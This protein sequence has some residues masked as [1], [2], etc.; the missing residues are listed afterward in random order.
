M[1]I[2]LSGSSGGGPRVWVSSWWPYASGTLELAFLCSMFQSMSA[3]PSRIAHWRLPLSLF[4]VASLCLVGCGVKQDSW[5]TLVTLDLACLSARPNGWTNDDWFNHLVCPATNGL[6][7]HEDR[8]T[9]Q[10]RRLHTNPGWH[11][12]SQ[13]K[14]PREEKGE[15]NRRKTDTGHLV[16]IIYPKCSCQ[17]L[18]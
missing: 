3:Y 14:T 8:V 12:S 9:P 10:L 11:G 16:S 6:T 17:C 5:V 18:L 4:W 7:V 2:F 15:Q 13:L 1:P